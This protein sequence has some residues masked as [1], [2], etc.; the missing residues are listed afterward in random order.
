VLTAADSGQV[1]GDLSIVPTTGAL[2]VVIPELPAPPSGHE[3]RCWLETAAGRT[4]VG[5]MAIDEGI[6]YWVGTVPALAAAP[7]GST[8]GISLEDV[9]GSRIDGPV[10][11]HGTL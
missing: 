5:K 8:F 11:F 10:V 6:S 1:K 3:Y 4:W 9:A 7:V 2:I